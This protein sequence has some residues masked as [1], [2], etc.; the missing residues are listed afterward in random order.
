MKLTNKKFKVSRD[1]VSFGH[2]ENNVFIGRDGITHPIDSDI[3]L[4]ASTG[5]VVAPGIINR[6]KPSKFKVDKIK[7]TVTRDD[8]TVFDLVEIA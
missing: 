6:K 5:E 3:F 2:I 8:G 4:S 1:G 7:K